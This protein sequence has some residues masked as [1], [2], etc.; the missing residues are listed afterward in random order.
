MPASFVN[1]ERAVRRD[2]EPVRG[3]RG[4]GRSRRP[5]TWSGTST[6]TRPSSTPRASP[7]PSTPARPTRKRPRRR[8]RPGTPFATGGV[9]AAGG[10]PQGCDILY[11][12]A[13]AL[14]AGSNLQ[15]L[16]LN[17]VSSPIADERQ[18]PLDRDHLA[19]ADLVRQGPS[20][21]SRRP[22]RPSGPTRRGR[23]S[24]RQ[25]RRA[26][27]RSTPATA[28]WTTAQGRSHRLPPHRPSTDV[29]NAAGQQLR[30]RR[31]ATA[32]RGVERADP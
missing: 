9:A 26:V 21:R 17:T 7:W 24:T 13:S 4:G 1:R 12:V 31:T 5:P 3:A 32:P 16:P 15:D 20:P 10:G 18:L 22:R 11:G 30:H 29:L 8:S 23:R 2:G 19:D 6:P 14:P 27:I 28:Q 25:S